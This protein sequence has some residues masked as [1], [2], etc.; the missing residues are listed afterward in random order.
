[1]RDHEKKDRIWPEEIDFELQIFLKRNKRTRNTG[2]G[3]LEGFCR[4]GY[5]NRGPTRVP[6]QS[7]PLIR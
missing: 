3:K 4:S 5:P 1:M 2:K 6:A 7:I